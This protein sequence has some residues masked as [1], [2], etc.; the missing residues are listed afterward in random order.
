MEQQTP[1]QPSGK[2]Y[3]ESQVLSHKTF[4][5][6][7]SMVSTKEELNSGSNALAGLS[8]TDQ[9]PQPSVAPA[10]ASSRLCL[11]YPEDLRV[12]P[13]NDHGE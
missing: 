3:L 1:H 6:D 2:S 11:T 7:S 12:Q 13:V 4:Q 10:R 9:R 5:D 8:S